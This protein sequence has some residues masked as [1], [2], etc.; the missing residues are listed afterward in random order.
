MTDLACLQRGF[1][2]SVF[3]GNARFEREIVGT[4]RMSAARRLEIYSHAYR[5]RLVETLETDYP[6]LGALAGAERFEHLAQEYVRAHPS[7]HRNLRWYGGA[8]PAF[9][10][11][12]VPS[13]RVRA[14]AEMAAFEWQLGL[15]FDAADAT[16]LTIDDIAQVP[17]TEWAGMRFAP[18]P[19]VRRLALRYNVPGLRAAAEGDRPLPPLTRAKSAVAWLV[20]RQNLVIRY[21]SLAKDEARALDALLRGADFGEICAQLAGA[22]EPALRAAALLKGWVAEGL[23]CDIKPA[24]PTDYDGDIR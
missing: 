8:L 19:S 7:S 1:Q 5:A 9:L 18:H 15:A 21:R 20:W 22:P 24:R 3:K 13:R 11:K 6:G 4:S 10:A 23:L 12:A 14:L 16:P 2:R 17:T